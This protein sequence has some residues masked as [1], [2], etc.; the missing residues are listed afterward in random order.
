[1]TFARSLTTAPFERSSTGWFEACSCKPASGGPL[2]S[3]VQHHRSAACVR[4][5]HHVTTLGAFKPYV[6]AGLNYTQFSSVE[7]DPAVV[8]ALQ[9]SVDRSSVGLAMQ[10]GFDWTIAKNTV[11]NIDV[12]KVQIRTDVSSGGTKVGEFRVDPLLIGIGVGYRF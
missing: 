3:S 8:A 5:T 6:G 10:V 2:P 11:F 12:K 7:F 1:M 9:P 4:D